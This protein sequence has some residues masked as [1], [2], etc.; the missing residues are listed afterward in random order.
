MLIECEEGVI[1]V[2]RVANMLL[3]LRANSE[4]PLGLLRA[5]LKVLADYL[6]TPLS[7]VSSKE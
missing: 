1:V 5:K 4:V 3:A 2:T 6:Y 7:I